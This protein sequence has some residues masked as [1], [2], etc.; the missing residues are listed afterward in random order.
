MSFE[1]TSVLSF[2]RAHADGLISK[3]HMQVIEYLWDHRRNQ[4]GISQGDVGRYFDDASSSFQPRFR[5][6][7]SV[8]EQYTSK[9][10]LK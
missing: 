8:L 4:E 10:N 5:E 3:R 6:L 1:Q 7:T 2:Q 9:F